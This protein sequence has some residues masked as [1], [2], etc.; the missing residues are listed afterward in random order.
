MKG[1]KSWKQ[2]KHEQQ[3]KEISSNTKKRKAK[4]ASNGDTKGKR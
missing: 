2:N 3:M 4:E 1:V